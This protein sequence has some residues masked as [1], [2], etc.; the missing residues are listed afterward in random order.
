MDNM[1]DV[2]LTSFEVRSYRNF[3]DSGDIDVDGEATVL[4]A[5]TRPASP[6]SWTRCGGSTRPISH[7]AAS[8]SRLIT[9]AG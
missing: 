5:R 1:G 4:V 6:P 9:P 2:E 7:H 3:I 8:T